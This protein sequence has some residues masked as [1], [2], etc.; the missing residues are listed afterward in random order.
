MIAA[1]IVAAGKGVRMGAGMR[2]QYLPLSGL[3]V[4]A[5]TLKAFD[6]CAQ[7]DQMVLVVPFDEIVYC[8]REI[9]E[10][11]CLRT[12]VELVAGGTR[13]QDSVCNGLDLLDDRGIVLIHDGV[14]P[15]VSRRLIE[16]CIEGVRQWEA[17]IPV[18]AITDTLKKID[19]K[20]T[21]ELTVPRDG[22]GMAQTPQGFRVSLIKR[23]HDMASRNGWEATDDA[24]LVERMGGKVHTIAGSPV[25]IKITRPGDLRW[26]E[27]L[28][29][30]R[31]DPE[32]SE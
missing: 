24:S 7:I 22:L 31:I 12:S 21:I 23:A 5:H 20:D 1:L 16:A 10:Q 8:R 15:L 11:L 32:S 25:N 27:A 4:L 26:A 13:R 19:L 17:C 18:V 6:E 29:N 28:L 30:L 14:R 9:I 3:P 2:K